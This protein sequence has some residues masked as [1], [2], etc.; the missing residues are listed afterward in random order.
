[1]SLSVL[2]QVIIECFRRV[3]DDGVSK[4]TME[5]PEYAVK[6]YTAGT[7]IR[8][9]IK[10][11]NKVSWRFMRWKTRKTFVYVARNFTRILIIGLEV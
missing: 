11:P 3:R 5:I 7:I 1:M 10:E 9:D 8:I 4:T 6:A 2:E